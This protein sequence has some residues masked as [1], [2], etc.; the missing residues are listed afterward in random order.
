MD[1]ILKVEAIVQ[2]PPPCTIPQLQSLQGKVNF[3]QCFVTNYAEI[4]KGF[5]HLLKKGF[6]FYWDEAAQHSFEA[7]KHALTS[8]P[9]LRPLDYNKDL[10][11]YFV[12]TKSTIDMVLVQEDNLLEQHVIYYLRRGLVG[13]KLNYSHVKKLALV[14]VHAVQQFR[15]YIFLRK[16]TIITILN[17]FQYVL[18]RRF[19]GG[20]ISRWIVILWEFDLDFV[21]AKPKKSLVFAELISKV[22]VESS[23][24]TPEE[25]LI[26]GDIFLITS[27]DSLYGDILVYI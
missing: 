16:T 9:L 1:N 12:A 21:S 24:V 23:D 18:T 27:S 6:P 25:L 11:L 19:I 13:P 22:L 14:T 17:P 7:L 4:T 26:K 2:L 8:S 3:L 15:H 20:K 5:M 10:L